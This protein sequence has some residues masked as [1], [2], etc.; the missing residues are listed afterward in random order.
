MSALQTIVD[1]LLEQESLNS[2]RRRR[3]EAFPASWRRR[4]A[5][6]AS[7]SPA[8]EDLAESFPALLFALATGYGTAEQQRRSISLVLAGAPLRAAADA[9]GVAWWLRKVPPSAFSTPLPAFSN[10]S[11]F[12]FRIS[13]AI[14]SEAR[15]LPAWLGRVGHAHEAC[16]PVYALWVARQRDLTTSSEDLALL[17][18]AWAWFSG[19][20]GHLGCQ[21]LR[22]PWHRDMSFRRARDELSIWH[23]RA[24]LAEFLGHGIATPWLANNKALGYSFV[25]LRTV[26]DFVAESEALDNCLDRYADHLYAGASA[27]FSIRKDARRIGCV[28]IGLHPTEVSMPSI[29]QLKAARNRHAPPEVWQAAY[30]W[31]GAQDLGTFPPRTVKRTNR[32]EGRQRLWEPYFEFLS[33]TRHEE[34]LRHLVLKRMH[35]RSSR[36][37]ALAGAARAR[38]LGP[39]ANIRQ[40]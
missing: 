2:R 37:P 9:L 6:L 33:G 22:T 29:V 19:Q 1:P 14:P 34:S 38:A 28:E 12:A 35:R 11:G 27:I 20:Q 3:I 39:R 23:Q 24:R 8:I 17:M 15:L 31:L 32:V 4:I 40:A 18:A 36:L 5:E 21:L 13:N 26:E 25:A 7:R 30:A 16:G 10:D